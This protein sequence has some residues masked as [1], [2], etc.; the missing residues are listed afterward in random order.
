MSLSVIIRQII[1]ALDMPDDYLEVG[2]RAAK[3]IA[4]CTGNTYVTVPPATLTAAS[5]ALANFQSATS[6]AAR[7]AA[8]RPLIQA[9]QAIMFLFQVAANADPE[10][11]KVIIESGAFK[12][13]TI[14][15]R[16]KGDFVASNGLNSGTIDLA[17][18]GAGQHSCHDW[19]YSADGITF[20]HM[21][22]TVQAHTQMTGLT[23][24]Q[25]AYFTHEAVNKDGG[26]GVS[27]IEKIMVK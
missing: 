3:I 16:Q 9:L 1:A 27:Q 24:G 4:A 19:M 18:P 12:V 10:N 21:A 17:A 25:Y 8:Y 22:P 13:K 15:P 14:N 6:S 26:Q 11:A 23:P 2:Q 5:N 7:E 20:A